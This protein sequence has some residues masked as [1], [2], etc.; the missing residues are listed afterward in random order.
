[1]HR[2]KLFSKYKKIKSPVDFAKLKNAKLC[3]SYVQKK[4]AIFHNKL[5]I[6]ILNES[7]LLGL[8]LNSWQEIRKKGGFFP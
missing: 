1:M 7:G 6:K 5:D 4:K 3:K 2:F 8:F